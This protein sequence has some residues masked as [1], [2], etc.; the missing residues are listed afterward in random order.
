MP[1][2]PPP[3][4][5]LAPSL[6]ALL[7]L[8]PLRPWTCCGLGEPLLTRGSLCLLAVP[9]ISCLLSRFLRGRQSLSH[10]P[11]HIPSSLFHSSSHKA[12]PWIFPAVCLEKHTPPV[13]VAFPDVLPAIVLVPL[14]WWPSWPP[15]GAS[16]PLLVQSHTDPPPS[17]LTLPSK[18]QEGAVFGGAQSYACTAAAGGVGWRKMC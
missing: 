17:R 5:G 9:S 15:R 11:A 3:S 6:G 7:R 14:S 16:D 13:S 4:Q 8:P 2:T 12:I 18:T 10:R 1:G